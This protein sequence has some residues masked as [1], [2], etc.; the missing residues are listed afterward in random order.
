MDGYC[1]YCLKLFKRNRP[2]GAH[3][4]AC[5]DACSPQA[6]KFHKRLK[7]REMKEEGRKFWKER[8][9]RD[10]DY[11]SKHAAYMRRWRLRTRNMRSGESHGDSLERTA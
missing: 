11:A 10:P 9:S 7:R 5:C 1:C 4:S 3:K 8:L 2:V 6:S